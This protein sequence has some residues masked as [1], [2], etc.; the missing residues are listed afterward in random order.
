MSSNELYKRSLA[1]KMQVSHVCEIGVFLPERSNVL[2][3]ITKAGTRAT[4]VEPDPDRILAIK[5]FFAGFPNIRLVP[6]AIYDYNGVLELAQRG[7][8][9]F[10]TA[11]PFSPAVVNDRYQVREEDTFSVECKRFDEIDD[12]AIDLLHIDTEG[13]EW[14]V[15]KYLKSRPGVISLETH[16]KTYSNPY[17]PEILDWMAKNNYQRWYISKSDSVYYKQ[18]TFPVT[19][20]EKLRLKFMDA[21]ITFRKFRK[22]MGK[23]TGL[24]RK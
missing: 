3:F 19:A 16:G 12:G 17:L 21:Y 14:F 24:P 9:T 6:Y 11:L 2:D 7:E 20:W 1:K 4:L 8:S 18:G 22:G 23:G 13:C 15:L 10:A 5:K